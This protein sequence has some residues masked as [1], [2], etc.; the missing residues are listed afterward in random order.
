[1]SR[2]AGW[3]AAL[4]AV[5]VLAACGSGTG[6]RSGSS[7]SFGI[8]VVAGGGQ[9]DTISTLLTQALVVQIAPSPIASIAH[10]VVQFQSVMADSAGTG[11]AFVASLAS[12][13]FSSFAVDTTNASGQ[14]SI[15]ILF[16]L[17][18]G[19][20]KIQVAVPEFGY[21]DTVTFVILPGR[22]TGVVAAP[23][24]TALYAGKSGTLH[25]SAVD[26]AGNPRP[27]DPVTYTVT[28]GPVT[29]AGPKVT[30]TALGLASVLARSDGFSDST[31]ISVVPTGTLAATSDSGGVV[32]FNIDGSGFVALTRVA[33]TDVKWAP[34]GTSV[35]FVC[36]EG[37]AGVMPLCT[38]DLKGNVLVLDVSDTTA[39]AWPFF[40]R[41]GT[42]IYYSRITDARGI[43]DRIHPDG[44]GADTVHTT[45][46]GDDYW[47]S[48]SPDG[49][50]VAYV[51]LNSGNLRILTL[52]TGAVTDLG[53]PAH[54]PQWSPHS[55]L[56]AYLASDG[57]AGPI[58]VA[59]AT[60]AGQ[61]TIGINTNQYDFDIDWSPD[62]QWVVG[63]NATTTL[64]EL[65]NVTSGL[66]LPLGYTGALGSPTWQPTSGD[67]GSAVA[68]R[69]SL[70]AAPAK[71]R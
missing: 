2:R 22:A 65:V 47:E 11:N 3:V 7:R 58:A 12:Q 36:P 52:A 34:S 64:L 69:R 35:V 1:M 15:Q 39:D 62:G 66:V 71:T 28:S 61:H 57:G 31:V 4:I 27:G 51:D 60:G 9:E 59:H 25:S 67:G 56:I 21:V 38:S 42:W 41:D 48:P 32:M 45:N 5:I 46:P 19:R 30:A 54:S 40:S 33:A 29:A 43:L 50:S 17:Q 49:D 23:K 55:D 20:A 44:T 18:S 63:R 24:D 68:L 8:R 10:Q 16:G 26:R 13:G 6:P 14:A 53:I 70:R 37:N